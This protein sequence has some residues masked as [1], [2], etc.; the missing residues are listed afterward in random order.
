M[1][2]GTVVCDTFGWVLG[3]AKGPQDFKGDQREVVLSCSCHRATALQILRHER[4]LLRDQ[5][6]ADGGRLPIRTW[7]LDFLV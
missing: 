1:D 6:P 3:T 2:L 7:L 4:S 5:R